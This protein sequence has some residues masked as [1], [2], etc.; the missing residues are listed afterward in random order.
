MTVPRALV[1][2]C[3][4][5]LFVDGLSWLLFVLSFTIQV[6]E[7]ALRSKA[8]EETRTAA[9]GTKELREELGRVHQACDQ[10]RA[11][12]WELKAKLQAAES[13]ASAS[14]EGACA[15][16]ERQRASSRKYEADRESYRRSEGALKV[17]QRSS[18]L[19]A[20]C[21]SAFPCGSTALTRGPLQS[22]TD[23][24][25]GSGGFGRAAARGGGGTG[26]A[27]PPPP[28]DHHCD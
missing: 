4:G 8:A 6:A 20:L 13:S 7:D 24:A 16:E 14:A 15:A 22:G 19:K 11:E 28:A 27:D 17:R 23:R 2:C 12:C 5:S 21:F 25:A 10:A 1:Q 9:A 18:L 26:S 3:P